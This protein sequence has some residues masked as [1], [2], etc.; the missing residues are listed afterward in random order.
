MQFLAINGSPKP[1]NSNTGVMLQTIVN[2]MEHVCKTK[3]IKIKSDNTLDVMDAL[4][5][6]DHVI[7]GLPLYGNAMPAQVL[8]FLSI[9]HDEVK[10]S[11]ILKDTLDKKSIGFLVQYG[12]KEAVHARPLEAYLKSYVEL[13]GAKYSGTIIKGGCDGLY[14]Q[15]DKR[16]G[17]QILDELKNLMVR[18]K[19]KHLFDPVQ[20]KDFSAPETQDK[21]KS[22]FAMKLFVKVANQFYWKKKLT[23]N[24]VSEADSFARPYARPYV[25]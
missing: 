11:S 1:V 5:Q 3:S 2:E 21:K 12:F 14:T 4:L 8:E 18:Y 9:L 17:K 24:G 15:K 16:Q 13:L 22:V 19:E 7:L 25:K 20:L 10:S 6:A 23:T